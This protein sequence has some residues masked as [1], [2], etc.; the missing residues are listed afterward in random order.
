MVSS[1]ETKI[2]GDGFTVTV[3]CTEEVQPDKYPVTEYVVE[4]TGLA[5]TLEPVD[6]LNVEDGLH[7]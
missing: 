3:N 6:E 4:E 1:G 5:V 2:A 7:I